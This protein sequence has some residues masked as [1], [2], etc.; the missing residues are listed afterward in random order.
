MTVSQA[1]PTSFV[2]SGANINAVTSPEIVNMLLATNAEPLATES[3]MRQPT[4]QAARNGHLG[5]LKLLVEHDAE[6]IHAGD[7]DGIALLCL[8]VQGE[9]I[10]YPVSKVRRPLLGIFLGLD[11]ILFP[12]V[13]CLFSGT[14]SLYTI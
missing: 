9:A 10:D 12:P 14:E 7:K 2:K 8:A 5:V 13:L 4:Q 6:Y 11:W 3:A 1:G